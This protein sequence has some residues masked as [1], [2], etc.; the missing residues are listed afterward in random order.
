VD[1]LRLPTG[2]PRP[3]QRRGPPLKI[4]IS[5][6]GRPE[7]SRRP[8]TV[9]LCRSGIFYG[10][11]APEADGL[12]GGQRIPMPLPTPTALSTGNPGRRSKCGRR[13]SW[14]LCSFSVRFSL[15]ATAKWI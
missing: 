13:E 4:R 12:S 10:G 6:G 9:R 15:T 3:P 7:L 2:T 14:R 1:K 5:G 11:G 8:R